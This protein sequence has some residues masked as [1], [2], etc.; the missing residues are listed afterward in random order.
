MLPL[1]APHTRSS[2]L[3]FRFQDRI[4]GNK[5]QKAEVPSNQWMMRHGLINCLMSPTLALT[6]VRHHHQ[7]LV[8]IPLPMEALV[9]ASLIVTDKNDRCHLA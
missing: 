7:V 4:T 1:L 5:R 9:Q 8:P 3:Y 6:Q 2:E